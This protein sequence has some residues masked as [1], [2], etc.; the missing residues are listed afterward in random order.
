MGG[1][2]LLIIINSSLISLRE[3]FARACVIGGS[4]RSHCSEQVRLKGISQRE[5]ER[6]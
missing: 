2:K 5:R 4:S 3:K 1:D 6:E